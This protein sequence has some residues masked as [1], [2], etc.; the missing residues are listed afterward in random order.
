MGAHDDRPDAARQGRR[1]RRRRDRVLQVGQVARS[2]VQAGHRGRARRCADAGI[3]PRDVDGFSS[4]SND[5]SDASRLSAALGCQQLSFASMQWG[6]GGGGGSGAIAN[7][8]AAIATGPGRVRRRV[9]GAGPGSVRPVRPGPAHEDRRRRSAAHTLP[10]GLMSAAQ[11]FAMKVNRFMHDH[12]VQQEALR[13]ISLASLR[14]RP[15]QPARRHVRPAARRRRPTT[16]RAGS[17]SR[18]TSSTAARR[19]TAPPPWCSS[20][21]SGPRTSRTRRATCSAA[22]S[23]SQHRAGAPVHN[24]PEYAVVELHDRRAPAVRHGQARAGRRRRAAE[25][26][27]LHRRRDDEHRRARLLQARRG[28]RVPH[29]RQPAARRAASCRSTPA[30]ATWPSAT[31]TASG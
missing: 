14:P 30:A 13:A 24:T 19:T 28:Q 25:L 9:P 3:D 8:A 16:R 5:R 2:R 7:G 27:E 15:A 18:S 20:P 12:G 26:R 22:V 6:G 29:R 4:Y 21:P 1:R 31:C 11:M 10:F 17:S 23:G